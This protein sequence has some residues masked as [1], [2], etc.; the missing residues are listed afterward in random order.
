[1][2]SDGS[3]LGKD[4]ALEVA[5]DA[6][7]PD[8]LP[9]AGIRGS[10]G[11]LS[12]DGS[13]L[14]KDSAVEVA[15][16]PPG[17]LHDAGGRGSALEPKPLPAAP[18]VGSGAQLEEIEPQ[19][20]EPAPVA[21]GSGDHP[22]ADTELAEPPPVASGSMERPSADTV[23]TKTKVPGSRG[24]RI[25]SSP[26][27]LASI[28]STGITIRPNS[29]LAAWLVVLLFAFC[30]PFMNPTDQLKRLMCYYRD[31]SYYLMHWGIMINH[32]KETYQTIGV[33]R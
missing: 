13:A 33:M 26:A 27:I 23:P 31:S 9:N 8:P 16:Q 20:A 22:S 24:P 11:P 10:A 28:S 7:P 15:P 3:A 25:Y 17:S 32:S 5:P 2:S 4:S 21:S 30:Y 19:P 1:M 6:Q 14:G 12:S 29:F 18:V